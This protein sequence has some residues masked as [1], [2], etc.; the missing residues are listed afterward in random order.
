MGD[1]MVGDYTMTRPVLSLAGWT[2]LRARGLARRPLS[3]LRRQ[4]RSHDRHRA[5]EVS[6]IDHGKIAADIHDLIM[7]DLSFALATAR[8][9]VDHPTLASQ[10]S[11]MVEAGERALAG[12]H[13]IVQNLV[14]HDR[15]PLVPALEAAVR[16]AG[17]KARV[18]FEVAGIQPST[19]A[20]PVT[21]DALVHI[22]REA[23][24]NAIKHAGSHAGVTVV[25]ERDD[26][27]RL[28][29]RDRGRGFDQ[30]SALMGFGLESMR[31]RAVELGGSLRIVSAKGTG[32]TIEAAL[33]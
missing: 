23:V 24:T 11:L 13:D 9:L 18:K 1:R 15:Q 4:H 5:T 2:T 20:D 25:L 27:W 16:Q 22:G 26:E 6:T 19:H 8:G 14:N 28:T 17:R 3:R 33:P 30:S 10:A 31:A 21:H 29:V 12:A 7:Q 32:S